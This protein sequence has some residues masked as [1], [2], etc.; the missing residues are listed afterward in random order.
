[1]NGAPHLSLAEVR[2]EVE[3]IFRR[4]HRSRALAL[5]GRGD[6][7]DFE[8]NG[9][10][11]RVVPTRCELQLRELLPRPAEDERVGRVY[12]IDWT[13][14]VLPLDIACRLAGGRLHHVARDARLAALFGARQVDSGLA[15]TAVAR[16]L[17]AGLT[18]APR[19]IQ[20]IRL[21]RDAAVLALLENRLRVPED[22]FGSPAALL[23]WACQSD[24]GAAF[25]RSCEGDDL[26]RNARRE[27]HDW[28]AGALGGA[29]L[30]VWQAWE[31]GLAVRLLEVL[32]L[33]AAARAGAD[34]ALSG[35]LRGQLSAWLG[36]LAA[37]VRAH[38]EALSEG[39]LVDAA[40]PPE[41][42]ARLAVLARSEALA[43][44]AG[45]EAIPAGSDWLPAGHRARE[46]ALA[47]AVLACAQTP[48][49]DRAAAV[50]LALNAVAAHHLDAVLRPDR[51]AREARRS[52][53]RLA[54]WLALRPA[55]GPPGTR[56]QPAVELARRYSEE[57][58]HLEW[59]RQQV[60][61]LR[62]VDPALQSAAREL[63]RAVGA[64]ARE[65]HRAFAEA[66]VA[67]IE[68][69]RPSAG[70]L[71]IDQVGKDVIAP[72]LN[73]NPRRKLLVVLMDGMSQA[74]AV[75]LLSRLA[76]ARR[77]GPI[78]W[79]RRDWQ[80]AMPLPP[81]L[82]VAPTL[83]ELSRGAFFAG[84]TDPRFHEEGTGR[85]PQRWR[86]H[87]AVAELLGEDAPALVMR[88]DLLAGHELA[89][90]IRDAVRGD[91]RAVA[92]VV[93]AVDEDLKGSLQVAK[94]Y[95]L[96]PVLPLE[97]LLSAAEEG[98]RVVLLVADHGHVLGDQATPS[99]GRL[100]GGRPGGARWRA[101]AAGEG[102]DPDEVVLPR[103][104]WTPR[105]HERTAVL[106]DP[107][108]VHRSPAYGEHGGLSLSEVVAP[109]LLIAPDWL[110]RA[111]PDDAALAVRSLPVPPWWE[112]RLP[113][114][115]QRPAAPAAPPEPPEAVPQQALFSAPPPPSPPAAAPRSAGAGPLVEGIRRSAVFLAQV[116]GQPAAEVERVLLWLGA[117]ADAGGA[118]PTSE[119]AAAAGVRPHQVGG[120]VARMGILNAD[121]F[122]MVEHDHVGRRVTL[123]RARLAQHYGVKE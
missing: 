16:L 85:D 39:A 51:A 74:V 101:L 73:E 115:S 52:A 123:H 38:E 55:G 40:L 25:T 20:G 64:V 116:E 77:W 13:A 17:L 31:Q 21:T 59:A 53:A 32:P 72:F 70:A 54:A 80:G 58:G 113:S 108:V 1:M 7:A 84:R 63:E 27:V 92:V 15:S 96:T 83:T 26:W 112:L 50:V 69:G 95:S 109:A 87:R 88:A 68:A 82:A 90:D 110:E 98:D 75:Q 30:A 36:G 11:W 102:P 34:A 71:P 22:A 89:G 100:G 6:P 79:R 65:D 23:V 9:A 37:A 42:A 14:D 2:Q 76:E 5:F 48:G 4:P 93:N 46:Q 117:L 44:A 114:R 18:P 56:W 47:A 119:F 91:A 97:A 120:A 43:A 8:L 104:A 67:W 3:R 106:W 10:P 29:G 49:V 60:R 105:G 107:A 57:G 12:L 86:E 111:V 33:L 45:L 19:K 121:G 99:P 41:P 94:D 61:G 122:A 78:A 66:C 62:G 28:V 118:L 24:G 81:V 103:S 35:Q